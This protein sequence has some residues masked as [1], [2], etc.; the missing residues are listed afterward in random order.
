MENEKTELPIGDHEESHLLSPFTFG[1]GFKLS[2]R[3]VLAPVTRCRALNNVPQEAHTIFYFQRATQGGFLISEAVAVSPQGI[4]FPNS[5][6]IYTE[7]Q[8]EAWRRV[9]D[10]VH[11][12]GAIFF[13]QLWHVGRASHGVYQPEG[14]LPI[15]STN[16][17]VP[18]PWSILMPDGPSGPYSTPRALETHE[19]PDIVDQFR[20][21]ARNAMRAG[22]DGIEI[23]SAH[24]YLIDQFLKD[25]IN[26]RNDQYG[27]SV[28]N[29][30]RFA[31]E[32]LSAIADEV[33]SDRLAI[34][35]SPIIDHLGAEDSNPIA[36]AQFLVD[37]LNWKFNP[38]LAYLHVTE[39]RFTRHGLKGDVETEKAER[40]VCSLMREGFKGPFMSSGG[41]VQET[42]E[43]ALRSGKADLIAFGRLFISNPDLP[44][45]FVGEA[46]L[47]KYDRSKFYTSD[48]VV[49]YTDYP[50]MTSPRQALF[51]S[52]SSEINGQ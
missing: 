18:A 32:I 16:Q 37:Q 13:C 38:G 42:G 27:G 22:F 34:R 39:P 8:V 21:A 25:G 5:P 4:G 1:R 52:F 41:F 20:S 9:V 19:I 49:G 33:G 44:A 7:E 47:T 40:N 15:S 43:A 23:H 17:P 28:A 50:C 26:D 10:A 48:Q 35:L 11:E 45:R 30:C 51:P 14:K 2:H 31:L 6:G 12:K 29:R 24:G 3:V 36:L 46:R